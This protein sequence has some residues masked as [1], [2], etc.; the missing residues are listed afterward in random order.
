MLLNAAKCQG[1]NFYHFRVIKGKPT[2]TGEGKITPPAPPPLYPNKEYIMFV[3]NNLASFHLRSK[4]N[5]VKHQIVSKYY[6]NDCRKFQT[7]KI[8]YPLHYVN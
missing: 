2:R 8:L 3:T 7:F 5:L 1:Y 6:E 4:E